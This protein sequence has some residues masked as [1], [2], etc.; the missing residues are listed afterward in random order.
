M[1]RLAV[2]LLMLGVVGCQTRGVSSAPSPVAARGASRSGDARPTSMSLQMIVVVTDGWNS[3]PGVMRRYERDGVRTLWRAVGPEVPVV[4]GAAGL[5][6]GDGLHGIASPGETGPIKKEG[7]NRSPAGVFRLTSAFGY[8]PKDSVSWI[9]MPYAQATD[10]YK[11]V[12]DARSVHY[13]QMIYESDSARV[14]WK[15]AED[16]HRPDSLY[17]MGVV[18]EHNLNGREIGGGSCIFLHIWPGPDGDTAGCTAFSSDA[19][20]DL[21]AWLEPDAIPI[22]VQ[23][24]RASYERLRSSW[25]LP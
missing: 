19:M 1:R 9:R 3:V 24:P 12:D 20:S 7:D 11:C 14:D 13:N 2:M 21:L 6:W 23:L 4:V 22:L 15:S 25:G 10:A 18:V 17:R 8:A 16:M 5:G